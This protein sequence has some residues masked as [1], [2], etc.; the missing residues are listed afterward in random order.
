MLVIVIEIPV[1]FDLDFDLDYFRLREG[2]EFSVSCLD[3]DRVC[4]FESFHLSVACLNAYCVQ[5][6]GCYDFAFIFEC[7]DFDFHGFSFAA[8]LV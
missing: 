5:E 2:V 8:F 1:V 6:V 4:P 3:D 7:L